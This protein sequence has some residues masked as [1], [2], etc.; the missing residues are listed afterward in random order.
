[1][2]RPNNQKRKGISMDNETLEKLGQGYKRLTNAELM[3]QLVF[4]RDKVSSGE[5]A[6]IYVY[7]LPIINYE[8]K[9]RGLPL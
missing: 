9:R 1:M 5:D 2:A 8:V 6:R 7:E 4:C 3:R